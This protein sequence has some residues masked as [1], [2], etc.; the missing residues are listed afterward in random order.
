MSDSK[1]PQ[2]R[3]LAIDSCLKNKR[4]CG[5]NDLKKACDKALS[6]YLSEEVEVSIRQI[7]IDLK[8]LQYSNY[9][10]PIEEYFDSFDKRKKY[11]RYSDSDYSIRKQTLKPD[12][13]DALNEALQTLLAF[14][15]RPEV[16]WIH[17]LIGR[18]L[19]DPEKVMPS[20]AIL[21]EE[22]PDQVGR[23]HIHPLFQAIRKKTPLQITYLAFGKPEDDH[24]ISPYLLKEY[25]NRWYI[26][27]KTNH[28]DHLTCLA[29]DRIKQIEPTSK[30][31][32]IPYPEDEDPKEFF[33]NFLGVTWEKRPVENVTLFIKKTRILY[34]LTKRIHHTQQHNPLP[35][36]PEW[37]EITLKLIPNK[38]FYSQML[39]FGDDLKIISPDSV[40]DQMKSIVANMFENYLQ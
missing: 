40:R 12:D 7:Q 8:Y 28:F 14:E 33:F 10:A 20:T 31:P 15:G 3:Y 23:Q 19:P 18:I 2:V 5:T 34:V 30:Y 32:F 21:Y 36:N 37:D 4:N 27:C 13:R 39:F 1:K 24:F 26:L 25:N 11:Y 17:E 29:L 38:E 6:D 16:E 9:A 35:E 22:N